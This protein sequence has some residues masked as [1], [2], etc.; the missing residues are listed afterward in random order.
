LDDF[1]DVIRLLLVGI[2]VD[3]DWY[4]ACSPG[5]E[6]S[7]ASGEF[8]SAA[9]HFVMHGYFENRAPY[10]TGQ[11]RQRPVKFADMM[12]RV[13][14]VPVRGHLRTD[15]SMDEFRA[16]LQS[17]ALSV[18]IDEDWYLARHAH[19]A[20]MLHDG[21]IASAQE[22]YAIHGYFHNRLPFDIQVDEAWYVARYGDVAAEI[23][24][25]VTSSGQ[26]HFE[27]LGYSQGRVPTPEWDARRNM[28]GW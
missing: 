6:K 19:A 7:F 20:V 28:Q 24:E 14:V 17:L 10:P 5:L 25:G 12:H 21:E 3:A 16:V 8:R 15:I 4:L 2:P 18:D 26:Q 13:R 27:S 11:G 23:A 9:H 22:H 1:I